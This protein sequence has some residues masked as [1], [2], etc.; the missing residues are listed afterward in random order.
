MWKLG[1]R[2]LWICSGNNEA[3]RSFISGNIW[4]RTKHL[5]DSHRP[6]ICSACMRGPGSVHNLGQGC[7]VQCMEI[8]GTHWSRKMSWHHCP[9]IVL[10]IFKCPSRGKGSVSVLKDH[11]TVL[12]VTSFLEQC[13]ENLRNQSGEGV[14]HFNLGARLTVLYICRACLSSLGCSHLDSLAV[15]RKFN[16]KHENNFHFSSMCI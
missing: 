6:F 16:S 15:C 1:E 8:Q 9:P 12:K 10:L 3:P 14:R 13:V 5:L 4:I 2:T 11:L 7:I